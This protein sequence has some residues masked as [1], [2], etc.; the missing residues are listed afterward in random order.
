MYRICKTCTP[1]PVTAKKLLLKYQNQCIPCDVHALDQCLRGGFRIGAVSEIVGRAGVGKT[2]LAMQLCVVAARLGFGSIF[3]DT[4][5]KL[6]MQRLNEIAKERERTTMNMNSADNS[7]NDLDFEYDGDGDGG[8][9]SRDG[10]R[11]SYRPPNEVL[12]NV[13]VH[14]PASTDE[15]LSIV[16]QL[17]EE[18]IIRNET[19]ADMQQSSC[20]TQTKSQYPVKLIILDSIAAPTRRD[21]GGGNAPQ[22]VAAIFQIAQVLKR[23]ADQMQVAVVVVNQIE[24]IQGIAIARDQS[25]DGDFVSVTA[26]LGTSWH[27]CVSTRV[28]LEHEKDPHRDDAIVSG[29]D[30]GRVRTATV[31]KSNVVGRSSASFEVTMM[32]VCH[33][34]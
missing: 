2:Q 6:S 32:G 29:L 21:F 4:E 15:L 34:K 27:H 18:I 7:R 8:Q 9:T 12:N 11:L 28:A 10:R 1:E 26:A 25:H 22:R 20:T 3:I 17:D 13:T 5:R 19:A 24:K 33:V 30:R 16:S 31:V 23:I 14:S